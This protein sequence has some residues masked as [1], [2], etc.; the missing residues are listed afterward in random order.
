ML[1][2]YIFGEGGFFYIMMYWDGVVIEVIKCAI[3]DKRGYHDHWWIGESE[4]TA[5]I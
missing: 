3:I 1:Q 2:E 5:I 4:P